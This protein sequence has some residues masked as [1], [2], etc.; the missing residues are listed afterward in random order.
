MRIGAI[1]TK[2]NRL[3]EAQPHLDRARAISLSLDDSFPYTFATEKLA[4]LERRQGRFDRANDLALKARIDT[5]AADPL[6]VVQSHLVTADIALGAGEAATAVNDIVKARKIA[7]E[8]EFRHQLKAIDD[9]LVRN[10]G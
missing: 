6:R 3:G 8:H 10:V 5:S 1:L 4:I 9:L 2:D 7:L